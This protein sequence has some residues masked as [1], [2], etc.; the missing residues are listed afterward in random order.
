MSQT[1][2]GVGS[3]SAG[4]S[5]F[6]Y[7]QSLERNTLC[8]LFGAAALLPAVMYAATVTLFF[9]KRKQLPPSRKFNLGALEVPVLGV[10]VVWLVFEL[11]IFRDISFADAWRY[12]LVM[13]AIGAVHLGWLLFRKGGHGLTM[14]DM[15]SIDAVF[16][17]ESGLA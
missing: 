15:H 13:V 11:A 3:H 8:T 1:P 5:L 12:V 6:G 2:S 17:H 16:H 14:P 7:G 4:L 9:L 10:A